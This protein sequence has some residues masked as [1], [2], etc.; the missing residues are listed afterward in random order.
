MSDS[1]HNYRLMEQVL[2]SESEVTHMIHLGDEHDDLDHFPEFT[3]NVSVYGVP[4]LYHREYLEKTMKRRIT[5]VIDGFKF[6][7]VHA[8]EELDYSDNSINF[9][10]HG[11]THRPLIEGGHGRYLL[12]PGHLKALIDRNHPASYLLMEITNIGVSIFLKQ[13]NGHI[14][15]SVSLSIDEKDLNN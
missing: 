15:K 11:H 6:Q 14:I 12:N 5:F 3:E 4:G 9:Y 13:Y 1:H 2:S 10:C 8:P 7:A